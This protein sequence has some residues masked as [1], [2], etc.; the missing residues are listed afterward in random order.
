MVK[1]E[2]KV[3][4]LPDWQTDLKNANFAKLAEA[5]GIMGVRIEDPDEVR[6]GLTKA[7]QHSG[8]ALVDLVT[9][10]N[11][12]SM[13]SHIAAG[14]AEGFAVTMGKLVLS[15]DIDEVV[16]TTEANVRNI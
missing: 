11:A 5:I 8:P 12:L 6:S 2:M 1:L 15:G 13:P 9:D 16:E 14:Q 4:G 7:L 3:A 10:P